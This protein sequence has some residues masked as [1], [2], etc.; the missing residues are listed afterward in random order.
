M[1]YLI[2]K[3]TAERA[4]L[5]GIATESGDDMTRYARDGA[6]KYDV[7]L[8]SGGDGSFNE[9]VQGLCEANSVPEFGYI[10]GGTVND[11]AR[12]LGI[13]NNIRGA[14]KVI[15]T[16]NARQVFEGTVEF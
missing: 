10:P 15:L 2:T 13:P 1:A 9:A 8:F 14:L 6:E 5:V 11:V 16:G 4:V 3:K 7:I 12:S